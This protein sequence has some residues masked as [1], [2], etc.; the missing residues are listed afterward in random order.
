MALPL[1]Y[2]AWARRSLYPRVG[3]L[4]DRGP[5]TVADLW[6]L[7]R[8]LATA[9]GLSPDLAGAAPADATKGRFS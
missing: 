7:W 8:E 9:S 5:V 2:R 4:A 6:G 1:P 3:E